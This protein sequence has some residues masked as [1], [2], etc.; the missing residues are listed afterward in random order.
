MFASI[1]V[2]DFKGRDAGNRTA[3][4]P[5][6]VVAFCCCTVSWSYDGGDG[7]DVCNVAAAVVDVIGFDEYNGCFAFFL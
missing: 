6:G 1:V 3:A 2:V 5:I 4:L 7:D